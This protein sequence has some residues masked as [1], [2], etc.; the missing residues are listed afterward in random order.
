LNYGQRRGSFLAR[1]E[2]LPLE[3]TRH[4]TNRVPDNYELSIVNYQLL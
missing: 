4:V 2:A 3:G 1:E